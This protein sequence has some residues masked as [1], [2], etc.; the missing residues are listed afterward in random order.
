MALLHGEDDKLVACSES[1]KTLQRLSNSA[2]ELTVVPQCGH[3]LMEELPDVFLTQLFLFLR[4]LELQQQHPH[5]HPP[6]N[7]KHNNSKFNTV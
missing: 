3:V 4:K 1:A 5:P 6:D 7:G 2:A